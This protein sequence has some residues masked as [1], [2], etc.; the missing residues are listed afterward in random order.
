MSAATRHGCIVCAFNKAS[1]PVT[2]KANGQYTFVML[3]KVHNPDVSQYFAFE[4]G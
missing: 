3:Y 4:S 1:M 2:T